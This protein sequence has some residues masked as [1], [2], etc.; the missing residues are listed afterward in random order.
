MGY[1]V[2]DWKQSKDQNT[3]EVEVG[4]KTF[5]LVKAEYMT[6]AQAEKLQHAGEHEGGMYAL[7]D[8]MCAGLGTAFRDVP[9]VYFREFIEAW[10]K[11]SGIDLGESPASASSSDSTE[12]PSNT[13]V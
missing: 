11:D 7:L 8:D 1:K 6:G 12:R 13:T 4:R 10:Q 5:R 9:M 2:P 3:F